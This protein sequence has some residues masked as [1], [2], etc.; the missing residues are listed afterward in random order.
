MTDIPNSFNLDGE[1][2]S[3]EPG[4]TILQAALNAGHFIRICAPIPNS[5]RTAPASFASWWSTT[6]RERPAR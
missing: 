2:I 4:Q 5:S 1:P 3:F 6:A